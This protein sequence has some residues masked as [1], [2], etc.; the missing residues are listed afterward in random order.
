M[1]LATTASAFG[2]ILVFGDA[3]SWVDSLFRHKMTF[4]RHL[5]KHPYIQDCKW[6]RGY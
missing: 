6:K 5:I 2:L 4:R 1:D 3:L